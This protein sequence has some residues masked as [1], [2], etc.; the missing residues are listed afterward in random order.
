MNCIYCHKAVKF[1]RYAIC[2]YSHCNN[3]DYI[4]QYYSVNNIITRVDILLNHYTVNIYL[5]RKR[6]LNIFNTI[7][8]I[9]L[10]DDNLF[11]ISPENADEIVSN[12][13]LL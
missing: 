7:T 9:D 5:I 4:V 1:S 10:Y 6:Q 2:D 12:L 8:G 3:H 11:Y 13:E